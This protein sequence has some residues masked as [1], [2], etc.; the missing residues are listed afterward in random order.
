[1]NETSKFEV[2]THPADAA[3]EG[4]PY[5]TGQAHCNRT[6]RVYLL[7]I[8]YFVTA[9]G[10]ASQNRKGDRRYHREEYD[11]DQY[12]DCCEQEATER[13]DGTKQG[14]YQ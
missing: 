11:D 10:A 6:R 4:R 3:K 14:Y 13:K 2:K 12:F 7:D 1:M 9:A 8:F 5:H